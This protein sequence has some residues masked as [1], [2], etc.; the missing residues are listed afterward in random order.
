MDWT[1]K[2]FIVS[3]AAYDRL[4]GNRHPA[5]DDGDDFPQRFLRAQ[6]IF[7]P[8]VRGLGFLE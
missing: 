6:I 8:R 2:D 4:F 3:V 5:E 7:R 1:R